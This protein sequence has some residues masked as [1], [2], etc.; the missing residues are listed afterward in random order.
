MAE[1]P[2]KLRVGVV[3]AGE[4]AQ[5]IHLPL[6]GLLSHLYTTT[7]ICDISKKTTD[8]CAAKFHIPLATTDP[9]EVFTSPDVDVVFVLTS[10]EFHEPYIIAALEAGKHVMIEKPLTLSLQSVDRILAAEAKAA[11]PIVFRVR[12]FPGPNPTF[13]AQSGAFPVKHTDDIPASA[14]GERDQRLDAL[15]KEAFHSEPITDDGIKL[16]RFM[17]TL[18]SHDISLM[19]EILGFPE[20]VIAVTAHDPI[21]TA[22][23]SYIDQRSPGKES[24]SV[25]YESGFEGVA[26]FDAHLAIYGEKKR[27]MIKYD[28][29]FVKGLP[30][31]VVV[32]E[33]N[34]FG[35][36]E[37]KEIIGN[38]EDAYTYELK[39]FYECVVKGKE[40]KTS[41]KD[42]REDLRLYD[43]MYQKW[44]EQK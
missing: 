35:E 32:Q 4:V 27:V 20:R 21:Y 2:K 43:L 40:V 9:N 7:A 28:S 23:F 5:V 10:D 36:I 29:P 19:R 3:G 22:I 30:I 38:Y 12:D 1:A 39:E 31:K 14:S 44:E 25:T 13:V 11:G 24:F 18:G 16:C 42:A 8:H 6:L 37:T 41:V 26:D 33:T 34:E 17:A 15:Y